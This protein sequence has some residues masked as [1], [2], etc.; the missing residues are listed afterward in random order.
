MQREKAAVL[1]AI[2]GRN[3]GI[4]ANPAENDR[5]LEAIA[6]L[7]Q[8][9]PIVQPLEAKRELSGVWR[10]LYTTSGELLG[11]NRLPLYAL[12]QIYQCI[13]ADA[14]KIYNIAE[15]NGLP[16]LGG[17]VSVVAGFEAVSEKRVQ[18]RFS[19][20]VF[21]LQSLVQYRDPHQLLKTLDS[22]K[23]LAA[24]DLSIQSRNQQ[25]WLEVT[26]LDDSL[27]I[28]RGNQGSV[29]VLTKVFEP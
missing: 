6:S 13:D 1:E 14:S 17:L 7:E 8:L 20:A 2:A 18:V 12:G 28:G 9:N 21:G 27:R 16:G 3:R 4:L 5:I 26:Y 29:F 24:I 19:R 22:G 11:L 23:R 10:L 15:V 25:G